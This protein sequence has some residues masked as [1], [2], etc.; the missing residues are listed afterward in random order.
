MNS[1]AGPSL[2]PK[3]VSS[4]E[5]RIEI[6]WSDAHLSQ[7]RAREVRLACRCAGCVEEW[8]NVSLVKPELVPVDLQAKAI[9][10]V[11]HYALHIDWSDGHNTGLYTYDY[12]RELCACDECRATR[13]FA[14]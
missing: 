6:V 5:G 1:K 11:G 8:T 12:L 7:Y 3:K 10:S 4:K 9:E 2:T 14:V 13:S